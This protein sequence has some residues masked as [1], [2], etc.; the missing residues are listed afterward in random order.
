MAAVWVFSNYVSPHTWGSDWWVIRGETISYCLM[1]SVKVE[2]WNSFQQKVSSISLREK[3]KPWNETF[4]AC[5]YLLWIVECQ[6]TIYAMSMGKPALQNLHNFLTRIIEWTLCLYLQVPSDS[7]TARTP[8][9]KWPEQQ[10]ETALSSLVHAQ[11]KTGNNTHYKRGVALYNGALQV[12]A[13]FGQSA[14]SILLKHW[15]YWL[16]I[17]KFSIINHVRTKKLSRFQSSATRNTWEQKN[18][19]T[20]GSRLNLNSITNIQQ[21]YQV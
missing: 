8:P 13:L 15:N 1:I 4:K 9:Q 7:G 2:N 19:V 3:K 17:F 14:L 10:G 21:I 18:S 12:C 20:L 6:S 16:P 5:I 11:C